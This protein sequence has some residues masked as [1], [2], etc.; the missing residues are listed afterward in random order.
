MQNY[1]PILPIHQTSNSMLRFNLFSLLF[2]ALCLAGIVFSSD[3]AAQTKKT[4]KLV[5]KERPNIV[6]ILADD[7]GYADLG[8]TGSKEIFTPNIDALANN[9]V[10]F[11]NGYVTHPYCG[12]SRAGLLTG[13]YQARFGMEVNAAHSP[14]DPYMGLPVEELTFAKRMQQAGYKTAVMGK[15]HMGSHPNFHPNNRGFDEFFG[16][17]GGGHDYFPESVKV[18]SAEYSI[19]LSRNGKP[20]QLNEYLTTAIS[21]EAA[22]FVSATEQPFM[23]YVAYNAP[24]SPLQATEQDLAKYQHIADLD[25]RTY[26][27]MIDSMDQGV[28]RIVAALKQSEKLHNTLIFFLSDNGGV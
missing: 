22:R 15:W 12:P 8:F 24:H 4:H 27:A 16:F 5:A 17:L 11:K 23:M 26:A 18:S 6:V 28:G 20:A 9:G 13:R 1:L 19:A 14:D 10:V 25:R 21:K 7:L 2:V 3:L